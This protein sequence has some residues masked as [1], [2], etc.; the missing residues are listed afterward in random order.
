M[1]THY[2]TTYKGEIKMKKF[3]KILLWILGIII[4]LFVLIFFLY[5][6]T[7]TGNNT[8]Q[9]MLI[10]T[11][12]CLAI[13]I[14]RKT[15]SSSKELEQENQELKAENQKLR[16]ELEQAQAVRRAMDR[17]EKRD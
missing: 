13:Y 6:D 1:L 2:H 8:H 16:Q 5:I 12:I 10:I 4:W 14:F 17:A 3:G 7:P 15:G 11:G 9:L